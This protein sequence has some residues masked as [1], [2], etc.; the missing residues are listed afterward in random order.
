LRGKYLA[1]LIADGLPVYGKTRL[2]MIAQRV[3]EAVGIG[4]NHGKFVL[5]PTLLGA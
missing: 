5:I 2:G 1:L 3:E 4:Y